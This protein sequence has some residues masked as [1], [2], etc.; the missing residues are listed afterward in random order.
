[1]RTE[2]LP[3]YVTALAILFAPE[4]IL[5]EF[6]LNLLAELFATY[7]VHVSQLIQNHKY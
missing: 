6:L 3:E 1:M 2:R 5:V 4:I 7:M